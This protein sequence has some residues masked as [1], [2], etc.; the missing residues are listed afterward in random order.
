MS[1][2]GINKIQQTVAGAL[3]QPA[4]Y[5]FVSLPA[6][7]TF[8]L[9]RET[10]LRTSQGIVAG[11]GHSRLTS[12]DLVETWWFLL[13]HASTAD[14]CLVTLLNKTI[15]I[16]TLLNWTA[17]TLTN[18][19]QNHLKELLLKRSTFPLSYYSFSPISLDSRLQ[20]ESKHLR[21]LIKVG[22]KQSK[23]THRHWI[24]FTI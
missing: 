15:G 13:D 4:L 10:Q 1:G 8:T 6:Q 11:P 12:A 17:D 2:E 9:S 16:V 19:N 14:S 22:F 21:T 24:V 20:G 3:A 18:G 23:P 5:C 7:S